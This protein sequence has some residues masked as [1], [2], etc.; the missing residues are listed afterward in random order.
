MEKN[1]DIGWYLNVDCACD[2]LSF[3]M[4]TMLAL[5]CCF[6]LALSCVYLSISMSPYSCPVYLEERTYHDVSSHC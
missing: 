4:D 5:S 6:L 3:F 1:K 2:A